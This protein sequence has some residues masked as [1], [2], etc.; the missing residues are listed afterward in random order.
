M[1]T[2]EEHQG[3]QTIVQMLKDGNWETV[4]KSTNAHIASRED[5]EMDLDARDFIR[6]ALLMNYEYFYETYHEIYLIK[7][8]QRDTDYDEE[9]E[10]LIEELEEQLCNLLG[11]LEDLSKEIEWQKEVLES[12]EML[13]WRYKEEDK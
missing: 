5:L 8:E 13:K 4:A 1:S 7:K 9:P 11:A 2:Q 6:K 3:S 12:S 10:W